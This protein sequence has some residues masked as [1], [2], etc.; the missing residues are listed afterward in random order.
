MEK[1][2]KALSDTNRLRIINLLWD[3]ELCVCKIEEILGLSQ[4]N[5]SRHLNKLASIG[6]VA[7]RKEAQWVYYRINSNFWK[8]HSALCDYLKKSFPK[9]NIFNKDKINLSKFQKAS[10]PSSVQYCKKIR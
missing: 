3:G 7:S 1:I 8:E 6:I 4:T 5:V 9:N 10:R 2:F